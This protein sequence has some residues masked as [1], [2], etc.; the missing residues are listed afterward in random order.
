MATTNKV[1]GWLC[2]PSCPKIQ[3]NSRP[4]RRVCSA[5]SRSSLDCTVLDLLW[6]GGCFTPVDPTTPPMGASAVKCWRPPRNPF[7]C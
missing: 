4:A 7:A 3:T 5:K 6:I 2:L 1:Q